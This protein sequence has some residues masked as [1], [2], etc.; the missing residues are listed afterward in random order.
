MKIRSFVIL[1][2]F[3]GLCMVTAALADDAPH[4]NVAL[5]ANSAAIEGDVEA[6]LAI[7]PDSTLFL[8]VN[9]VYDEDDYKIAGLRALMGSQIL[10][11]GLTGKLGFKAM[12]GETDRQGPDSNIYGLGFM[13]SAVYD[14]SKA[15]PDYEVPFV[16]S[17]SACLSP[18]PLSVNDTDR[19]IEVTADVDWNVLQNAAITMGYRY[20]DIQFNDPRNWTEMNNSLYLGFK[21]KF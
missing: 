12:A 4:F 1:T 20:I 3:L 19:I 21:F 10:T 2:L 15:L 13:V 17:A 7:T 9:G 14:L 5:K 11:N 16:L 18:D 8:G 6:M